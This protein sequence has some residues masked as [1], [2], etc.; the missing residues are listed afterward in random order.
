VS[1][2]PPGLQNW[3]TAR[4][5]VG[6]FDSRP[7][8]PRNP[9]PCAANSV[10]CTPIPP[11]H[12][13]VQITEV[14]PADRQL[15]ADINA[16]ETAC[17]QADGRRRVPSSLA[18]TAAD[19]TDPYPGSLIVALQARLG[20]RL[21]GCALADLPVA[22]NT[23]NAF[24]GI[25]VHPG[26]RRRGAGT[27]LATAIAGQLRERGRR[28]AI[29]RAAAGGPGA[30]FAAATGALAQQDE[31]FAILDLGLVDWSALAGRLATI[32][33]RVAGYSVIR[34]VGP[35]PAPVLPG[36]AAMFEV[37]N[38]APHESAA[39]EDEHW[40]AGRVAAEDAWHAARGERVYTLL[41]ARDTDGQIVAST[42]V[43]VRAGISQARQL[44][45]AVAPGHRG[46]R[47][48]FWLKASMLQWL[49]AAEPGVRSI[50]T[51]NA[52]SN[53]HMLAINASL[54]FEAAERWTFFERPLQR[55]V[56]CAGA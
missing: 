12:R 22:D 32:R 48:G 37:M 50:A 23:A 45:T 56:A 18:E 7:P 25:S 38:D 10:A 8:P 13:H 9:Q 24:V 2:G 21:A 3:W 6:G 11:Q 51:T 53:A 27:A 1:G 17:Y 54:G 19:W 15:L 46:R 16:L 44:E 39:Q 55:P 4:S 43:C 42:R 34:A 41:A 40:T 35:V 33:G 14:D 5:V 36:L 30:R 20:G 28:V 31:I 52:A 49:A 47:L 26:L 29:G